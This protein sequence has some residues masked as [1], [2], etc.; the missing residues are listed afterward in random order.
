[1][2]LSN[3]TIFK[4]W[5]N[6]ITRLRGVGMPRKHPV[7]PPLRSELF[8]ADQMEMHGKILATSHTLM[9]RHARDLL[10][11]RL[12][13]NEAILIDVS[14]LLT[15]AVAAN[16]RI[17]PASEWLL[18][19][20]YLIEEQIRTA[21]RHL[22]KGYSRELPRLA[23]G[24][25]AELPRV[26]DL[27]LETIAHGDGRVDPEA[28]SRFVAAY[29]TT[30]TLKLGELWAIP[31]MLRLAL[32]ENLR[33]V[34]SRIAAASIDRDLA[35]TWA[36]RMIEVAD[37]NPKNLILVL[38]DMARSRPPLTP[39]FVAEFT[40][41]LQ[42][43]SAALALPLTWIEQHLA[44]SELTI[45]QLVQTETQ[46]QAAAQVSVSNSIGSLRF[47]GAMDWR[48]FVEALSV[49]E[50]TLRADPGGSYGKMDFASRDSYRHVIEKI[51]KHNRCPERE[52]A[53]RAL[54]LAHEAAARHGGDDRTAHVGFYLIGK[55]TLQLDQALNTQYSI[56]ETVGRT[57]GRFPLL[58]Y[59]GG[60]ALITAT[61][62]GSLLLQARWNEAPV[63][64]LA[65]IGILALLA[66]SQLAVALVNWLASLLTSPRTLPRMDFSQGIPAQSRTL[67]VV[68]TMLTSAQNTEELIEALEVRFLA[69]RD[70]NLLFG[71]LTDFRDA[72]TE[73]LPEDA[74]LL[75]LAQARIEALNEKYDAA[76]SD[77]FLLLQ[78]PRRWNPQQRIWMGYERKRGK[79]ADLN[80]LLRGDADERFSL[81]VGDT[82]AL[83]DV[84]YVI[85]LDTDT[86]LPRDA[87]RQF[88]GTMAHPLNRPHYDANEQRVTQ[89]YGILQPRVAVSL[90]GTN[91]SRYARLYGGEPGIDPYTRSVSDVYQDLFGEGSFIGK[92]IYDV[93]AFQQS[94]GG[95]FPEN[96]VLS[97]DLLEGCYARAGLLSDVQM[98]EEYPARYSADVKRRHRWIRGDWQLLRWLW[99]GVPGY[100]RHSRLKNPLTPLSRWKLLDNLRRSLVPTALTALLLLGWTVLS[101]DWLWTGAVIAIMVIPVLIAAVLELFQKPQDASLNQH[102]AATGRSLGRHLAQVGLALACLPY[103]AYFSL[104]AILRTLWRMGITHRRLLEWNPSNESDLDTRTSLVAAYRSMWVAPVLAIVAT[105]F[106]AP[107][108]PLVLAMA[109][110]ILLLWF[111]S[112]LITW[113]ISRPLVH[114]VAK[115]T[116]DQRRF[117][118][119]LARRTWSFF[120][121]FVGPD[122]HWLPPD[123]YQEHP[124]AVLA[125][126]TSPTNM[127]L[128]LLA[129]LSA[130]DFGYI[131]AGRF[132]ERTANTL[133]TMHSLERHRGHFY[134][135]YDTQSLQP[136]QPIYISSVDSGNL[137]GHLLTLRPG[138]LALADDKILGARFF[139][140]LHDTLNILVET[141]KDT[142][143]PALIRFQ[144]DLT[145]ACDASPTTLASARDCLEKLALSAQQLTV[146]SGA[147]TAQ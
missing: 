147:D 4:P 69:N 112:P 81:I 126:R 24:P 104:D 102:L 29:Q 78:R 109:G 53:E 72:D 40:R 49:V 93:D 129:N 127:G 20:F 130:Y 145:S 5:L 39:P 117:L 121:N 71:L 85:T 100:M 6:L 139:Q 135:W 10:L 48:D 12:A 28:L 133:E 79:L 58:H 52:V 125:H 83:T 89:G 136:L 34:A 25:S 62:T 115:L 143:L 97:H 27:A 16:H 66:T 82:T 30:T 18:D 36:E 44:E 35:V 113:W 42:G 144:N 31:I 114:P 65:L 88:V 70:D 110:P 23:H 106:L 90:P 57:L 75:Q 55:G 2:R 9:P 37:R 46:I 67:V 33:R 64:L 140:G 13:A 124:A 108:E 101:Q 73:T 118:G 95:R 141:G 87:A 99:P 22:P 92:G 146:D 111:T 120:E 91:R 96:R 131:S 63:W 38:A 47:L 77:S 7:E 107:A 80:A 137:A 98:Y 11:K 19:N 54:Q 142:H 134:N 119:V 74:A 84:K 45:E 8:S 76:G 105:V 56:I 41:R 21:K 128:A 50:Q 123:N 116:L 26:Y 94:L 3:T 32:I 43:H 61:A 122:E 51:A 132:V 103:E 14:N 60:I 17:T 15:T 59:L 138:L 86:Q 68:P 1:M